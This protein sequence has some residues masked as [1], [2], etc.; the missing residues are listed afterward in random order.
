MVYFVTITV[1]FK[2]L[3]VTRES[4]IVVLFHFE[5]FITMLLFQIV[6]L[7]LKFKMGNAPTAEVKQ[8]VPKLERESSHWGNRMVTVT[9]ALPLVRSIRPAAVLRAS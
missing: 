6:L 9:A 7:H 2:L 1:I 3:F 5:I 4:K 8:V